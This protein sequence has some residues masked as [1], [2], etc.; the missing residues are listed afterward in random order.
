MKKF[1]AILLFLFLLGPLFGATYY[2]KNAGDDAKDGL[3]DANA[4]ETIS[5][6]NGVS[7]A[8]GDF[9]YFNKGDEWREQLSIPTAGS[10]GSLITFGAYG[11]GANPIINGADLITTWTESTGSTATNYAAHDTDYNTTTVDWWNRAQIPAAEMGDDGTEIRVQLRAHSTG[12]TIIE[13]CSVGEREAGTEDYDAT[14]SVGG[15]GVTR[16]TFDTGN[17]GKTISANETVWSD[18]VNYTW[19]DTY[20]HLI[21]TNI[22]DDSGDIYISRK[23]GLHD[24][25]YNAAG[26][27]LTMTEDVTS[28]G[29]L[30]HLYV[31]QNIEI[32]TV[33]TNVWQAACA[34]A[35]P[36]VVWLDDSIG[37]E[38]ASAVLCNEANE[39]FW[40]ANVLY[41]YSTSDPDTAYTSP[42]IEAGTR[43][44]GILFPYQD[45]DYIKLEYL[46]VRHSNHTGIW[47]G[48]NANNCEFDNLS[49]EYNQ[50]RDGFILT[51]PG[52]D[53]NSVTNC[54]FKYNGSPAAE[55]GAGCMIADEAD[56]NTIEDCESHNNSE[57]GFSVGGDEGSGEGAVGGTGNIF[58]RC[59]SHDNSEDGF[60][61]KQG[62]TTIEYC[63]ADS[64][65]HHAVVIHQFAE[66]MTVRYNVFTNNT[67]GI[68]TLDG[69]EV[70]A[71]GDDIYYNVIGLK[72]SGGDQAIQLNANGPIYFYNNVI[73]APSCSGNSM[74]NIVTT[75]NNGVTFKNNIMYVTGNTAIYCQATGDTFDFDNNCYVRS[76]GGDVWNWGGSTY[77][78]IADWRTNSSQD[79]SSINT[80]PLMLDPANEDF[81]TVMGSVCR[82][83]GTDVSLTVDVLGLLI[84]HNPDIGAYEDQTNSIF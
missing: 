39:W 48:S 37:T 46:T 82:N 53:D 16:I 44:Y 33:L 21:H 22:E 51:G 80:D 42:G 74:I 18:W 65:T 9:V 54:T 15:A 5:K 27:D 26:G 7:F 24:T 11:T 35:E 73:Y 56:D 64:N 50:W 6:V 4:W 79:A 57:D 77:S 43:T 38:V 29:N 67:K 14:P 60:D 61:I 17:N 83:A 28:G 75:A 3:S 76:G 12:N 52:T 1:L 36:N 47:V 34:T 31:L 41:I 68:Y 49:V 59:D 81:R 69:E 20:P 66:D 8:A 40:E 70:S 45:R 58:R 32:R 23:D 10:V 71:G 30:A 55:A 63:E 2:V 84:R 13:G 72:A 19:D 78:A 25:Y 62:P